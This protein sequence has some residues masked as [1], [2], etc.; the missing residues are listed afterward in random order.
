MTG[1]NG[2]VPFIDNGG[3][4]A[5]VERRKNTG[6]IYLRERRSNQD[7]RQIADRRETLNQ[8]R[9]KERERRVVFQDSHPNIH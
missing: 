3:Q 2:L 8:R 9:C 6:V 5:F 1:T 7:R 4:R